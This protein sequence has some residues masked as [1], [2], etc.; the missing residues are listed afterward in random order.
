MAEKNSMVLPGEEIKHIPLDEI[1]VDYD[2]NS[3][4]KADV[5][6]N[7]SDG[8]TDTSGSKYRQIGSGLAGDEKEGNGGLIVNIY[9]YGQDEPVVLRHVENGKSMRGE[10]TKLKFE[11][12]SGFRR[13]T[14]IK[15][16]NEP[17][18]LEQAAKEK[19]TEVVPGT[20]NGTIRAVV[21]TLSPLEARLLNG[22]ENTARNSLKVWDLLNLVVE[23]KK[24]G[25][26]QIP[27]ATALNVSQP[28]VQRLLKIS[29]LPKPILD[30]WSGR[31]K[32]AGVPEGVTPKALSTTELY[33]LSD[34]TA[35]KPNEAT[36][37]Y[38]RMILPIIPN[39]EGVSGTSVKDKLLEKVQ[40]TGLMIGN[41]VRMGILEEGTKEWYR[42]FGPD[43]GGFLIDIGK[44]GDQTRVLELADAMAKAYAR[45]M[46]P[47]AS[48]PNVAQAEEVA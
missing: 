27:I 43:K 29:E 15:K 20:S 37:R 8:A 25:M 21:R 34:T 32:M 44:K 6:A 3:R 47:P 5:V 45:G 40:E 33:D 36:E 30:H 4:S 31:A 23:L 17:E 24:Q 39:G 19:R 42:L 26:K 9:T 48:K 2:W 16:L 18:V 13:L 41:L 1:H 7:T 28:Y 35:G 12:V 10:F 14:A 22:R 46:K 38:L 11:L